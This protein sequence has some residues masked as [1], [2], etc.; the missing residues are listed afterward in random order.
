MRVTRGAV[1]A[2]RYTLMLLLAV[3]PRSTIGLLFPCQYL[4][5]TILVTPYSMVWDWRVSRAGP[6]LFISLAARS[7]FVSCC[8]SLLFFHSMGWYCGAGVFG[9]IGCS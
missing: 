6:M 5:G 2:H 1:I 7:L 9:L 3:E 4:C 8:F